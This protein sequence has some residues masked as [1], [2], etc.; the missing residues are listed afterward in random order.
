MKLTWTFYP[1]NQCAVTL[2]VNY[3]AELDEFNL[4]SGG[5]L[6][7]EKNIAC[8]DLKTYL[9]FNATSVEE[10]R[11][12]FQKLTRLIKGSA[13]KIDGQIVH[14]IPQTL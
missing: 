2:E 14:L 8:V 6:L 11:H 9:H 10:R 1:R 7:Q 12:A 5:F 13:V 4:P 3:L